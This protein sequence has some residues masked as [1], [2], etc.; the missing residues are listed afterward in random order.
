MSDAPDDDY[1]DY[2]RG[3]DE[4]DYERPRSR[5]RRE[6]LPHSAL[7]IASFIIAIFS[8]LMI[9]AMFVII[10]GMMG[11]RQQMPKPDRNDPN[12]AIVGIFGCGGCALSLIGAILGLVGLLLP[13]RKKVFAILGFIFNLLVVG[14]VGFLVIIGH[15]GKEKRMRGHLPIL[16][17]AATER[18]APESQKRCSLWL[19]CTVRFEGLRPVDYVWV[20]IKYLS[21]AAS[22]PVEL[23]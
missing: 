20:V 21:A 22:W 5:R 8:V 15:I 16:G 7:G 14:F 6:S 4:D 17:G 1:D 10:I 13:D 12:V 11:D 2:D 18:L 23:F 19:V 3:H 9:V